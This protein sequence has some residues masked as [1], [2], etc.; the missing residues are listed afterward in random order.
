MRGDRPLTARRG[1]SCAERFWIAVALVVVSL[2]WSTRDMT[3]WAV[4]VSWAGVVVGAAGALH[5]GWRY[6][7]RDRR[8]PPRPH[9]A[10]LDGIPRG[11][12][13]W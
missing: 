8:W 13:S 6:A 12:Q 1:A 4:I 11:R 10:L 2:L 3:P 9:R 5:F 7:C